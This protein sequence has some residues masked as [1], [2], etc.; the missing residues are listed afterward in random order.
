MTEAQIQA[1]RAALLADTDPA[2]A[3][4]VSARSDTEVARLYN[5]AAAPDFWCWRTSVRKNEYTQQVSPDGTTFSWTGAG[6]ITR[7]VGERDA[8][9]ELFNGGGNGDGTTDPS[10]SNVRQ[11]FT[12]IFSGATAPAPANRA[13][14][15]AMSRRKAT[16]A[17]K[18]FATGVGTTGNPGLFG[19]QGSITINDVGQALNG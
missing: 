9:R 2:V 10:L 15:A 8:W 13:H 4:A 14:L 18:A 12:D 3:A 11:A 5:E 19:F 16:R 6:F 17:E 1:L 7:S